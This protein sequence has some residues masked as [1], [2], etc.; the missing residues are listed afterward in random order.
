MVSLTFMLSIVSESGSG[1]V[2]VGVLFAESC[3]DCQS[4]IFVVVILMEL[5]LLS[6]RMTGCEE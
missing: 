2:V 5:T 4:V 6:R 3:S 1:V